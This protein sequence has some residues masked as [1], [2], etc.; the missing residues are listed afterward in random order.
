MRMTQEEYDAVVSKRDAASS[1]SAPTKRRP[2]HA[3]HT[4]GKMNKTESAYAE[5][6]EWLKHEGKVAWY[7][8]EGI[9]LK[10]A[11]NTRYT[12]DFAVENELGELEMH[13]V[14][15]FWRDDARVK[16]KVAASIFPFRFIA[17]KMK[18]KKEGGG[19]SFENF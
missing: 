16:I 7:L 6:L 13:E 12:P 17:V 5:R 19:W 15:G 18:S 3:V 14:K 4:P 10:L 1:A 8:F 11:D 2:A 9:T